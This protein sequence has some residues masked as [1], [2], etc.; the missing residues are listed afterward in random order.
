[1]Y[2]S[3]IYI[4]RRFVRKNNKRCA[5]SSNE[6]EKFE[7]RRVH[8]IIA[9][10]VGFEALDDG[11]EQIMADDVPIVNLVLELNDATEKPQ[12]T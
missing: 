1:M 3:H 6:L 4:L 8:Q 2:I 11:L 7:Q 9:M 10:T 12:G 5:Y